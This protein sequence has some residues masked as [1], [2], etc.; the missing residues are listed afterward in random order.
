[1]MTYCPKEWISDHTYTDLHDYI[2]SN[3]A[4]V[5]VQSGP[6]SR[7]SVTITSRSGGPNLPASGPVTLTWSGA[8]SDGDAL[9]YTL[10]YSFDNRATWRTLATMIPSNTLTIDA[11]QLEG[12]NGASTAYFRV[13]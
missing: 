5:T 4:P 3:F 11:S 7:P 13:V 8:D 1:M 6:G 10:L 12:T 2:Q 9:R